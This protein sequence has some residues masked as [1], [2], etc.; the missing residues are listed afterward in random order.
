[1]KKNR[2]KFLI[3]L[4]I[5]FVLLFP[6]F[7]IQISKVYAEVEP[8]TGIVLPT[9]FEQTGAT[10]EKEG[11]SDW[12]KGTNQKKVNEIWL[13][14]GSPKDEETNWAYL[15]LGGQKR[16]LVALAGTFGQTGDY[17]DIYIKR[18]NSEVVYPCLMGDEKAGHEKNADNTTEGAFYYNNI[19]YGHCY[20]D[21]C[22][23]VEMMLADYSKAPS[24][25]FRNNLSPVIKI[26]NGGSYFKYPESP[27]GLKTTYNYGEIGS[28]NYSSSSSES[29]S[30]SG[31]FLSLFRN[32][33]N[34]IATF[35]ENHTQE[36]EDSTVMYKFWGSDESNS[37]LNG[38]RNV[39][40]DGFIQY[41]QGD[42][43]NVLW[44]G[45]TVASSGCGP[46][47]Y[48]MVLTNLTGL[49]ITP[50][51]TATWCGP[52]TY[53]VNGAGMSWSYYQAA[54]N[55]FNRKLNTN[56][57]FSATTNIDTVYTALQEGKIVISSQGPGLFTQHGHFIV[58]SGIDNSG[59]IIVKDPNRKN[60]ETKGYNNRIFS[61][62]EINSAAKNYWIFSNN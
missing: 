39:T 62:E 50:K 52:K 27:V 26:V 8:G 15:T 60:A 44:C 7:N 33:W 16:F 53:Y 14:Q 47:S 48:A 13:E 36:T 57:T 1:M 31:S 43:S 35:F 21:K 49:E 28:S 51:D 3:C 61:K 45:G 5:I 54:T 22:N 20:G 41:Y 59:G 37:D 4:T 19:H 29:D 46:T 38:Y 9:A 25:T 2:L 58:L 42:Y 55:Y 17:V 18:G 56:I 11:R 6:I 24:N 23:V 10:Y 32:S 30:I 12:S 40:Q 34:A